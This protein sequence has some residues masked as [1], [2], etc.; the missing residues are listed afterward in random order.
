MRL[1]VYVT[2]DDIERGIKASA[3]FCPVARAVER[4]IGRTVSITH[5]AIYF[6]IEFIRVETP[7]KVIRFINRFDNGEP[8]MPMRFSLDVPADEY[9]RAIARRRARR[10]SK[11]G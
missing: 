10:K 1:N 9:D 4:A 8:V 2:A 5:A 6:G 3:H 11:D 7:L